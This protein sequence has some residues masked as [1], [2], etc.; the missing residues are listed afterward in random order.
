MPTDQI[1]ALAQ[2][3]G[4]VDSFTDNFGLQQDTEAD[5][6]RAILH[7]VGALGASDAARPATAERTQQPQCVVVTLGEPAEILVD[8]DFYLKPAPGTPLPSSQAAP[9]NCSGDY[10]DY[11]I[12]AEQGALFEG[13]A[14][15]SF[16][17]AATDS[18]AA[19][20]TLQLPAE[21]PIGYH[22]LRLAASPTLLKPLSL[23]LIVV[24]QQAVTV[25]SSNK[26]V[27]V[28]VQLYSLQSQKNWGMGDFSDLGEL[29]ELLAEFGVDTI[30]VNPLHVLYAQHPERCS[31]YS[32]SSRVFLNPLYIDVM[33]VPGVSKSR[34][35]QKYL[36]SED[37]RNR[38][39]NVRSSDQVEYAQIARLKLDALR[40]LFEELD[41]FGQQGFQDF[42]S[43]QGEGLQMHARFEAFDRHFSEEYELTAWTEWP[44]EYHE[45]ST[46]SAKHWPCNWLTKLVSVVS[47]NG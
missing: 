23:Q 12:E 36:Q 44:A 30:G 19:R 28:S 18:A 6:S 20:I 10:C 41:W 21:L 2:Q 43:R 34:A 26:P 4:I 11:V 35:L 25:E 8:G 39:Q 37:F 3:H 32:P 16:A 14:K 1:K 42:V 5:V 22:H 45:P 7:A 17:P 27:G 40:L 9:A 29:C 33:A 24:P 13:T 46:P 38:L 31:P 47:C 15:L